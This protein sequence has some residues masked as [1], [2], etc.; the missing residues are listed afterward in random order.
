VTTA[1]VMNNIKR[2]FLILPVLLRNFQDF[3]Y[4]YATDYSGTSELPHKKLSQG[5]M[6]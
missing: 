4:F 1:Q 6:G 2:I 5:G 3:I